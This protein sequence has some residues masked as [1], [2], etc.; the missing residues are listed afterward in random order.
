M[1]KLK[2]VSKFY[3]NKGVVASGFSKINLELN[4]GE[5][6]VI[7]GESG[8][9]KSTLLNVIS[10]LDS[11]EEGEM[12][13]NGEETSYFSE[14]DFE[15]YR[16][17][18]IANIFQN[19]NLI[20]SYT[21]YQN[22]ELMYILNNMNDDTVKDKIM[23]LLEQVNLAKYKNT[24]VS[25]LSGGQKQRVAIARALAKDTPIIVADEPTGNL[26]SKAAKEIMK[27]L[28]EIS[29]DKLVIIVT[30]NYDQV[31][32]YATRKIRM[33][34]GKILEDVVLSKTKSSK[35][36]E[37]EYGSPKFIDKLKL[38]FRNTF[39]I[40][41]KFLLLLL[42]YLILS[43]AVMGEYTSNLK[44]NYDS[45]TFG[46][47]SFFNETDDS[48]IIVKKKDGSSI[49]ESD[50]AYLKSVKNIDR[51]VKEDLLLDSQM[52][53]SDDSDFNIMGFVASLNTFDGTLDEGRMPESDNEVIV[54][55]WK[56]YY[57]YNKKNFFERELYLTESLTG[58]NMLDYKVKIVGIKFMDE[59]YSKTRIYV[60]DNILDDINKN[61]NSSRSTV[62]I[63]I[64]GKIIGSEYY[65]YYNVYPND[66]VEEGKILIPDTLSYYCQNYNCKNN[67]V[68]IKTKNI[69]YTD[70]IDL[71]VDNTYNKNSFERLTGLKDYDKYID[72]LFMNTVDYYS[73]YDK[74]P[75]QSS[76]FVTDVKKLNDTIKVLDDSGYTTLHVKDTLVDFSEELRVFVNLF[77]VI[78][79]VIVLVALFFISYFV[80]KIILKSRNIYYS[81]VRI[82]GASKND[83][84]TL[85]STELNIVLN[86]SYLIIIIL[87][88]LVTNNILKW[89]FMKDLVTYL[90]VYDYI[91]LYVILFVL[92]YLI[93]RRYSKSLFKKSAMSTYREV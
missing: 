17:K 81:T 43:L 44:S 6:V 11:Y 89:N 37:K 8:S 51:V 93:S 60:N 74:E 42:V 41:P 55:T 72:S 79:I 65:S 92:S 31:E 68:N 87:A 34:D 5:F 40:V 85:I 4:I 1:L 66:K 59:D 14:T 57:N 28:Y 49:S 71:N 30:H 82:L 70:E 7:T 45:E 39:N 78:G 46:Y 25:K 16:K 64:N 53:L 10:G 54:F 18:Y 2:N 32:E 62:N 20:N 48:R 21:V 47:S 33:N 63:A 61:I 29:K 90:K 73:L 19:F 83:V 36:I 27:L 52:Y 84:K 15:D 26:D 35:Y 77:K 80:I 56:D 12:Y 3:Y 22:I 50:Y 69:Y 88:M 76:V 23:D 86:I 13:I 67:A 24:K 38:S 75:Y 91:I 9:G 58:K